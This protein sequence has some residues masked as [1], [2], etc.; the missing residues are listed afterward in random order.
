MYDIQFPHTGFGAGVTPNIV[1]KPPAI[2]KTDCGCPGYLIIYFIIIVT[3][4]Y[5]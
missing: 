5:F 3:A 1:E 4:N 2:Q